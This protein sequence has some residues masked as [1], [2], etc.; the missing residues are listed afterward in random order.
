M[1]LHRKPVEKVNRKDKGKETK[2]KGKIIL[3]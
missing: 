2:E 1:T 3:K